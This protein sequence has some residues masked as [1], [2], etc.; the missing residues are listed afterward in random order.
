MAILP[1]VPGIKVTIL[2][3]GQDLPEYNDS[4]E[5]SNERFAHVP[6]RQRSATY[7]EC[8]SDAE[9]AIAF[10]IA[11]PFYL[12]SQSLTLRAFVDGVNI[13]RYTMEKE[14]LARFGYWKD[15]FR[16]RLQRISPTQATE[17]KLKFSS[18][19]KGQPNDPNEIEAA[20]SLT[21]SSG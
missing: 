17:S 18:I 7:V 20:S 8:V 10:E 5:W 4:G 16:G 9:F 19:T 21:N 2:S 12:D 1:G 11:P 13:A 6:A 14:K 15:Q 3:L